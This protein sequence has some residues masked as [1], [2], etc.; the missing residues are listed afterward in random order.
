MTR[1]ALAWVA[2]AATLAGCAGTDPVPAFVAKLA[3]APGTAPPPLDA[4]TP[5]VLVELVVD[6]SSVVIPDA[7]MLQPGARLRLE[8]ALLARRTNPP[9]DWVVVTSADGKTVPYWCATADEA[10]V[11]STLPDRQGRGHRSVWHRA[12]GSLTSVRVPFVPRGRLLV[13]TA[14]GSRLAAFRFGTEP[15][16][17]LAAER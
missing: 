7:P 9:T 10:A 14:S 3:A 2:I 17:K 15:E 11:R 4:G 12:P 6:G 1:R 13:Y 16:A 8:R 5:V